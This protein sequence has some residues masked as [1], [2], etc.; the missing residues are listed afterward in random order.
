MDALQREKHYTYADYLT[1][2]EDIRCELIDG[3][4]HMLSAPSWQH[5]SISGEL[6]LQFAAFLKVSEQ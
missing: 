3:V 6:F 4:I 2:D 5:Q 1:W